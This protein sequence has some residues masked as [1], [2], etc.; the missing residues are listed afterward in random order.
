MLKSKFTRQKFLKGIF[1]KYLRL[2]FENDFKK[3]FLESYGYEYQGRN[4]QKTFAKF[5]TNVKENLH[6]NFKKKNYF[7]G[8]ILRKLWDK[9]S[10]SQ[11]KILNQALGNAKQI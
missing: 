2:T 10:K 4:A 7:F 5:R 11:S 6:Q 1:E 3:N 8:K 9:Y